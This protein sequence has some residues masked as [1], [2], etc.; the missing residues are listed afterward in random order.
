LTTGTWLFKSNLV[1]IFK[2]Y[3]YYWQKQTHYTLSKTAA[4]EKHKPFG[5][6]AAPLTWVLAVPG[7]AVPSS[8]A[9]PAVTATVADA[10]FLPYKPASI[11][12]NSVKQFNN[13]TVAWLQTCISSIHCTTS[14]FMWKICFEYKHTRI[15]SIQDC[16]LL[17]RKCNHFPGSWNLPSVLWRC[18]FSGRKGSQPVKNWV[19]VCL[20]RVADLHMAQLMPLPLTVSCFSK[21]VLPFWYR[22]TWVVPEKGPLNGCVFQAV[23]NLNFF[24]LHVLV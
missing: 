12:N 18:W 3:E 1:A 21:M 5:H 17:I 11:I 23:K 7:A 6:E 22:L 20:E 4:L 15:Y 9:V 16:G 14:F 19:V 24:Q 2:R 10:V 13:S 8:S